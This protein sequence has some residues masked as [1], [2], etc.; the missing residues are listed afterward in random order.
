MS[1]ELIKEMKE[2]IEFCVVDNKKAKELCQRAE[3]ALLEEEDTSQEQR[4]NLSDW[5]E[6]V[7]KAN[8]HI[9]T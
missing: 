3:V 2:L 1:K 6:Q 4:V 8:I 5:L 7:R 9:M